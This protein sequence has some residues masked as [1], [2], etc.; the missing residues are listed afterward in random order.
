HPQRVRSLTLVDPVAG[1]SATSQGMFDYPIV[2]EWLWQALA[3][4]RMADGQAGD[5]VYPS[6]FPGWA[7]RYRVQVRYRGF[8]RALLAT[9]RATAGMATDTLYRAVAATGVPVLLIWGVKDATVPFERNAGVRAAIPAA[10]FH[11]IDGAGHLPILEQAAL[12][13]SLVL[14]FLGRQPR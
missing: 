8:G 11:A 5:F 1:T 2:G 7:D 13:D 10:E 6:R 14:A 4:P 3:V 9:R 12:T